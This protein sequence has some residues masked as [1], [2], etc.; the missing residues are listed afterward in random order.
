MVKRVLNAVAVVG[1]DVHVGD[2]QPA[3]EQ[4]VDGDHRVVEHA[5]TAGVAGGGM[6]QTAAD[7]ERGLNISVGDHA[8]GVQRGAGAEHGG[9]VH[10]RV[11][12]V[13]AALGEPEPLGLV[14]GEAEA[15]GADGGHVVAGVEC[16]DG[17]LV[18]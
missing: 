13:V 5:E 12:W 10:A 7:V 14:S 9:L 16:A 15:E 11:G 18:G 4:V 1:V 17:G 8:G 2:A 3:I 6:M